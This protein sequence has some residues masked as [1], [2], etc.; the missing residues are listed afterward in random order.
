MRVMGAWEGLGPGRKTSR[1]GKRLGIR[2]CTDAGTGTKRRR[3]CSV[4]QKSG[5][6]WGR[7]QFR[8][9]GESEV[10]GV[11]SLNGSGTLKVG[12]R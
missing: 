12:K 9:A 10:G 7:W 6:D 4:G 5:K 11:H 3:E 1:G 2:G 8:L